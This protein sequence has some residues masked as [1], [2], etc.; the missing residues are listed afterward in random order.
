MEFQELTAYRRTIGNETIEFWESNSNEQYL[1]TIITNGIETFY[2]EF[3]NFHD[4][5]YFYHIWI[6]DHLPIQL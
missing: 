6:V 1:I 5:F 3:N 4:A 2:E